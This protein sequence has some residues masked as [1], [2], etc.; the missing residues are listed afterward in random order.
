ML[1]DLRLA[2]RQLAKSPGFTAVAVLSLAL[3]IG[4]NTAIFSLVNEFL[5]RSLPVKAPGELV[6]FRYVSGAK[7]T[8]MSRSESGN[9]YTDPVTGLRNGTSFPVL[10][11]ERF[12]ASHPGLTDVF[13]YAGLSQV[14]VLIDGQPEIN[15]TAQL[16]SGGY[17]AGLGVSAILG[18][19][20]TPDDDRAAAAPVAVISER[21]WQNRFGRSP[22]VLGRTVLINKSPATIVGVTAPG[23]EGVG[24]VGETNDISVP[25]AQVERYRENA[26]ELVQGWYWWI[27]I[28]GP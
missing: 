27:R 19:T 5:L 3:G 6:L 23:F 21:Y 12:Q 26:K 10:V 4:A 25:L 15:V 7:G 13:A 20:M 9:S 18:R 17:H 28:M 8:Q 24:Q 2:L 1:S 14:N 11:Y 22:D 16:V